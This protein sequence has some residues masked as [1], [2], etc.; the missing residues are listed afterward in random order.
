MFDRSYLLPRLWR[1]SSS[2]AIT[3]YVLDPEAQVS[4]FASVRNWP[5]RAERALAIAAALNTRFAVHMGDLAQEY[6]EKEGAAQ[7]RAKRAHP[8]R[9]GRDRAAPRSPAT[10][11]SATSPTPP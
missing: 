5:K 2:S 4:E 8:A 1:S 7:A 6:P 10:W 3:H 9:S 11:T